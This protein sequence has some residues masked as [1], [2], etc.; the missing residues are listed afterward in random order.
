MLKVLGYAAKH[1]FSA[2]EPFEFE[3]EEPLEDEVEIEVLFCG[4]CH[5]DIHQ[6]KDEW[7]NTVYPCVPGHEVV[8]RVRKAGSAVTRLAVGEL[9]GVGCMMDSCRDCEACHIGDQNYCQGPNSWLATY[10]GP[11]V[12]AKKAPGGINTYGRHN[13]FGGYSDTLVVKQDFVLKI[14]ASLRPEV[15][16]P[17]LCAGVTTY[18]PMRHWQVSEAQHVGILGFGGLGNMAAKIAQALGAEV[19]VFTSTE[20]KLE[21]ASRLGFH[22]VLKKNR[23]AFTAL[24]SSFDF[25]LSTVPQK[26]DLNPFIPLLKRDCTLC[27]VGALEPM[28]PVNN[29]AV[30]M[31]RR[32]VAGSLIGN[33]AET[34]EVL[35]FCATHDIGPDVEVIDIQDV[36]E[37]YKKVEAGDVRFR[38]VIDMSSLK[39]DA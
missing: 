13:T 34:Q 20:E 15:A 37:C 27:A 1:S 10:N 22:A 5:S 11:M 12:A 6:V 19:T 21:A 24:K 30:A 28:E 3:R 29:Q 4:I 9:V 36:N 26:H 17:I 35:D 33:L 8:G 23:D 7:S 16:A 25:M 18:S 2:L 14:P 31:L 38:Y 32:A 39:E